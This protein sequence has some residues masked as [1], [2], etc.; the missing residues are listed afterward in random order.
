MGFAHEEYARVLHIELLS[1]SERL[2]LTDLI[3]A[4]TELSPPIL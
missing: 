3:V 2:E 1:H 4:E